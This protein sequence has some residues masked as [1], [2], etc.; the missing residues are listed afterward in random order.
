[1]RRRPGERRPARRKPDRLHP[2]VLVDADRVHGGAHPSCR[3]GRIAR[4]AAREPGGTGKKM[5]LD[6]P[7]IFMAL[8]GLAVLLYVVLD[9]YDLGVGMLLPAANEHEQNVMV[10]SIGPF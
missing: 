10:S 9:G 1:R 6:L 7:V 2:H 4:R 8:M 3:Q 5:T